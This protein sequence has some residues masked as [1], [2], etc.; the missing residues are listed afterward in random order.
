M[1]YK[2]VCALLLFGFCGTAVPAQQKRVY[3]ACDDH[4]DY[5][6]SGD[7]EDYR[8]AFLDTLDYYLDLA[9]QTATNPPEYQSRWNCDGSFWLWTYEQNRTPAQFDRLM[10]RL[11]DG[12]ISAPLNALCVCLGGTPAEA[13]LR[14][15]YYP[16]QLERRYGLR[17]RMAYM[18]ENQ[19]LPHGLI[20]LWAGSGAEFSW[21]GICGCDSRVPDAWD[22]EH[23]IYRALGPD[24]MELLMKWNSMLAGNQNMGGYAEARNPATTIDFVTT[25]ADTNGFA[26]RYPYDVIGCFGKGWDDLATMTDQFVTMA[27]EMSDATRQVI[28]SNES[29]FFDDFRETYSVSGL[30]TQS[31]T[32]GNEWELY[33]ATLAEISAR[34]KRAV[35]KLRAA[36]ALATVATLS[37]PAFMT[38][39][40]TARD[41]AFMDLGLF[42]EHD[43]GMAGFSSSHPWTI[44]RIAWQRRLADEIDA[45]VDT[46]HADACT[47]L[48]RQIRASGPNPR[49]CVFN[50]LGWIRSDHADLPWAATDPVHVLEV[51]SGEQV[52]HEFVTIDGQQYLRIAAG[53]VPSVGYKV[54]EVVPGAGRTFTPAAKIMEQMVETDR[55][56]VTFTERGAVTS[57]IDRTMGDREFVRTID[58]RA[59]NDLGS[60]SGVV[61]VEHSGPVSVTLRADAT[62][63]LQHT[64]RLTLYNDSDRI[65]LQ[66]E[67]TQNFDDTYTWGFGFDLDNPVFRHEE[68]GAIL[69]AALTDSGGDYATRNARYDWLTLNHFGD[70]TGGDGVGVTLS[71]ADCYF[72]RLGNSTTALL[73]ETTP[74]LSVLVGGR[75]A[76]GS[77]GIRYQ[78]G[79]TYFRQRFALRTHAAYDQAG[80]MRFALEHQ[81]P[82]VCILLNGADSQLPADEFSLLSVASTDVLLW[83]LKPAEEDDGGTILRLWNTSNAPTTADT[84]ASGVRINAASA[85]THIETDIETLPFSQFSVSSDFARQQFQTLR[86]TLAKPGDVNCDG[87]VNGAD[88]DPFVMAITDTAAYDQAYP[89]CYITLADVNGDGNVNSGDIDGFV[90]LLSA[91]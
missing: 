30:P 62:A 10:D 51:A 19:T 1:V 27:A 21:K 32:F 28:V 16:G 12:H 33:C 40:E 70:M 13:V 74:A 7:E 55:Y 43:F 49:F 9:D 59:V 78:G 58:G 68:V 47:A 89:D 42:W 83:A 39:R 77:N 84:V 20:S 35:E 11:R 38:G 79:D 4:T 63:P 65:E 29:D 14:G 61:T 48:A 90:M 8:Q 6:W 52:P 87:Y 86:L 37:E 2:C 82:L 76:N 15:M 34:V 80:A 18:I 81:N 71:N 46:L 36:E 66:N 22:R 69:T 50:P 5:F 23:E 17:F 64:T 54:Y 57:I 26:A 31:A 53:D 75:V 67:I 44:A 41:Q 91:W 72:A 24:G 45:Y 25:G 3:I 60:S 73:D 88:I 85:T 56:R